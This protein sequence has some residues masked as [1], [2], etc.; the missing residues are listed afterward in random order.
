MNLLPGWNP[1]FIAGGRLTTLTQVLSSTSTTNTITAPS[2]IQA[3]DLIIMVDS[4]G[5]G[6]ETNP[7][8]DVTPSG[9]T[10]IGTSLTFDGGTFGPS[11]RQNLWYKIA[12]GTEG[13]V[14]LTGLNA[15]VADNKVIAVFRGNKPISSVILSTPTGQATGGNP[16]A[17]NI[18]AASGAAP[19]VAIAAYGA[20]DDTI[21]TRTFTVGGVAAKDGEVNSSGGCYL[22]WKIYNT[23]P[24]NIVIDMDDT[25]DLNALQGVYISCS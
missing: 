3:G 6:V 14:S 5:G 2:G 15:V 19:L 21:P 20:P 7:P 16:T 10:R 22:A 23:A 8:A 12:N 1:G 11:V 9:F 25:G 13:G 24:A 18:D 4:G 17:Q